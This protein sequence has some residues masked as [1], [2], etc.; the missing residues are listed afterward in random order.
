MLR[1]TAAKRLSARGFVSFPK[2]SM[3]DFPVRWGLLGPGRIAQRFAQ[4]LGAV[5]GAQL[6]AVASRDTARAQAFARA[7]GVA[8]V[9]GDYAALLADTQ[10]DAVYI[11]T[12]HSAH[13]AQALA[14]VAAGKAVLCE[15]P[16]TVNAAQAATMLEAARARGVFVMEA[17]WSR[18]LPVY[19]QVR[20]WLGAGEIGPV[21]RVVSSFG[22]EAARN[23]Q[24][25]LFNP[26]LAGGALLDLGVYTLSLPH[27]LLGGG[28]LTLQQAQAT[29]GPT[30]VDE[31]VQA[32]LLSA[33][34][35]G[36][37]LQA[38]L[39]R[40]GINALQ[41][42]G[43]RGSI[44]VGDP[45]WEG[46]HAVWQRDGQPPLLSWHPFACNGF[47]YQVRE[48]QACLASGRLQ[49]STMPWVDTLA[50]MQAMDDIRARIGLRYPFES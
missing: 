21:L 34:G 35:V 10:V 27:Y 26:A 49:S 41:L 38:S 3:S 47:E 1:Q 9:Y 16:L 20:D 31:E 23:P 4:C 6:V 8:R 18:F 12:P 48:V 28:A 24:D 37:S 19:D 22:F 14:V 17:L 5:A 46:S 40:Q 36:I 2:L 45:F 15:K 44:V 42:V 13:L 11:A 7:H 29:L 50:V 25:R 43:E 33:S 32:R 39:L 30:G